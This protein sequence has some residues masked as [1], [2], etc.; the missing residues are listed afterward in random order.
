VSRRFA[1]VDTNVVVAALLT[2]NE[3]APVAR[4][5]EGM[6]CAAFPFVV[7]EA[8]LAEYRTVLLRPHLRKLHGMKVAQIDT[9]LTDIALHAIVM[10]PAASAPAP[11]PGDQFLRDLLDARSDHLLVTG[12]KQLL[13]APGMQERVLSARAFLA[14]EG[15]AGDGA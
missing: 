2:S 10:A 7:S 9:L 11:D 6:L 5:L 4:V 12:D 13:N 3:A 8:L 15:V 1:I 14:V